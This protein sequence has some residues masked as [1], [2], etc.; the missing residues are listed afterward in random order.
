MSANSEQLFQ[1]YVLLQDL[2]KEHVNIHQCLQDI[3]FGDPHRETITAHAES[4]VQTCEELKRIVSPSTCI[5][6]K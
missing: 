1:I 4:I 5:C 2:M 6:C 3:S